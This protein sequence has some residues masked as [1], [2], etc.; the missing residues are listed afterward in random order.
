VGAESVSCICAVNAEQR[1]L[2]AAGKGREGIV[3]FCF[4]RFF[5]IHIVYAAYIIC[6]FVYVEDVYE[7]VESTV[8]HTNLVV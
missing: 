3:V 2:F 6:L 7:N 8:F 1:V 4:H 5:P